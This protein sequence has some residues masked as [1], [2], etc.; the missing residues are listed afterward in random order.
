VPTNPYGETKL[1]VEKMLK[2]CDKAYGI[3]YTCL[4]YFNAAGAHSSGKIGEDHNP[5]SHLIPII[6]QTALGKNEQ[7]LIYGEDY[8]TDDGTCVR[9]YIHVTD[10]ANAHILALKRLRDGKNSTV[11][12]LGTG[13]RLHRNSHT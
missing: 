11:Y 2:W 4:R 9:D 1:T 7:V 8:P 13:S 5:E 10:L 12:N 6:L 3:R